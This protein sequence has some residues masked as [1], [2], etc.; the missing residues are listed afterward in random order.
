MPLYDLIILIR[1]SPYLTQHQRGGPPL[2]YCADQYFSLSNSGISEKNLLINLE[3]EVK[4]IVYKK[5]HMAIKY[6]HP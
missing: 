4:Y 2:T 5:C 3:K 1:I 6:I